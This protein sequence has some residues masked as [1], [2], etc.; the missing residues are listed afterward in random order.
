MFERTLHTPDRLTRHNTSWPVHTVHPTQLEDDF[1]FYIPYRLFN[2]AL[3]ADIRTTKKYSP[4][5][6]IPKL[7][8]AVFSAQLDPWL[9]GLPQPR[10]LTVRPS[11]IP[12]PQSMSLSSLEGGHTP[13]YLNQTRCRDCNLLYR[14]PLAE[15]CPVSS[16]QLAQTFKELYPPRVLDVSLDSGLPHL[17]YLSRQQR[18]GWFSV[19]MVAKPVRPAAVAPPPQAA[20]AAAS[21]RRAAIEKRLKGKRFDTASLSFDSPRLYFHQVRSL[22]STHFL[23][24]SVLATH[25]AKQTLEELANGFETERRT[26]VL[27]SIRPRK[28]QL[29]AGQEVF[30]LKVADKILLSESEI[31]QATPVSRA[32]LYVTS[33]PSFPSFTSRSYCHTHL[34]ILQD[35]RLRPDC[36]C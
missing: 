15:L 29:D 25:Q 24:S 10:C 11:H 5:F 26:P 3:T 7:F 28:N 4:H 16:A 1:I 34:P 19:A 31:S 13:F 6:V 33:C 8:S 20:V 9:P 21:K 17:L 18:P 32:V 12:T 36:H 14:G 35:P 30:Y 27:R 22:T 2:L 23:D